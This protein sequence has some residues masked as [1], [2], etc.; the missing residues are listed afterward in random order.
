MAAPLPPSQSG[1]VLDGFR[2]LAR[3]PVWTLGLM[4]AGT[5]LGQLGPALELVAR[6]GGDPLVRDAMSLATILPMAAYLIPRWLTLL[7]AD[8]SLESDGAWRASFEKRWLRAFMTRLAIQSVAFLL[9]ILVIPSVVI[10]TLLGFAPMRILLRGDTVPD[11][12]RWSARSMA[13]HWPRIAQAALLIALL[14]LCALAPC[15]W[16]MQTRFPVE[17]T[18]AQALLRSPTLWCVQAAS[19]L[20]ILWCS[21]SFL[22]LYRR[23]E[24]LV[25]APIDPNN[26]DPRSR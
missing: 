8:A 1:A 26:P 24:K 3:R 17:S 5:L 10:L 19:I 18:P 23:L 13:R 4:L 12:L 15:Q 6:G 21:A 22:S 25:A 16:Y 9:L 20:A 7:D 14:A 11:A 2:F